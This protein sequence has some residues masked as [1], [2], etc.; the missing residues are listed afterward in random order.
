MKIQVIK[1]DSPNIYTPEKKS[2]KE[3]IEKK[4]LKQIHNFI[5]SGARMFG[6]DHD[7][8]S[9]LEDIEKADRLTIFTDESVN[10]GHSL[11]LIYYKERKIEFYDIG[12]INESDL[13]FKI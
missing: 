2:L 13:T 5:P 12:K 6:A 3:F 8:K 1:E 11:V 9:V 7:V 4:K 10:M